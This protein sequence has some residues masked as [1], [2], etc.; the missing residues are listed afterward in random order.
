MLHNGVAPTWQVQRILIKAGALY[1]L[2]TFCIAW[3]TLT[4]RATF[5]TSSSSES[6]ELE[7][8]SFLA[9]DFD[10]LSRAGVTF[11]ASLSKLELLSSSLE[12]SFFDDII[13]AGIN[14]NITDDTAIASSIDTCNIAAPIYSSNSTIINVMVN[15]W[16]YYK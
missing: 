9:G 6:S 1:I 13:D 14:G 15:Q 11:T 2:M 10:L 7:L 12:L 3:L 8:S 4:P 5:L 16:Q